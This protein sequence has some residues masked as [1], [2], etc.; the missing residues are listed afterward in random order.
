[1][2]LEIGR[3]LKAKV[4]GCAK[5]HG[6]TETDVITRIL[7]GKLSRREEGPDERVA[8]CGVP[9]VIGIR[10][11]EERQDAHNALPGVAT[12]PLRAAMSLP[13]GGLL[14]PRRVGVGAAKGAKAKG[15]KISKGKGR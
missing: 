1:M 15:S 2:M 9:R 13:Y 10:G 12:C 11:E 8:H 14:Q 5:R 3:E 6:T 4:K 7:Y